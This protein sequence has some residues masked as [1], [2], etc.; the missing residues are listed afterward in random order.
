VHL[1]CLSVAVAGCRPVVTDGSH[2]VSIA[3]V[4][5]HGNAAGYMPEL[6]S[7][8]RMGWPVRESGDLLVLRQHLSAGGI[9][10][11]G[12]LVDDRSRGARPL[13]I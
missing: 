10:D 4:E 13:R 7:E 1:L 8:Y 3:R 11:T 5:R 2:T 12:C 6:R 9:S